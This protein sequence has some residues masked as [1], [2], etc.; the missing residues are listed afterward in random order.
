MIKHGFMNIYRSGYFHREG[1]PDT[2]N[3]HAGDIYDSREQAVKD[4]NP[5]S[6]YIATVPVQWD[7]PEDVVPNSPDSVPV[8]LS[9]SRRKYA[10]QAEAVAA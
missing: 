1:K 9:V 4:I 8:S 7:D 10:A 3:R 2:M 6:H 5:P